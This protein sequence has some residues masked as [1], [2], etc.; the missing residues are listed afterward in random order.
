MLRG[1]LP[2]P[3]QAHTVE[4]MNQA[5]SDAVAQRQHAGA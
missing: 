1:I 2:R 3:P 4:A 5:V